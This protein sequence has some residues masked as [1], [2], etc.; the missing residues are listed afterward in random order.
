MVSIFLILMDILTW[1]LK[2]AGRDHL[3]GRRLSLLQV[4]RLPRRTMFRIHLYGMSVALLV[5]IL[6]VIIPISQNIALD[7]RCI[8]ECSGHLLQPDCL[9]VRCADKCAL[10]PGQVEE[11]L[12][13]D[14]Q[15]QL[16]GAANLPPLYIS[17]IILLIFIAG[18]VWGTPFFLM[19]L[20]FL[21]VTQIVSI[22][23]DF[24]PTYLP[25]F[26]T[27]AKWYLWGYL[28]GILFAILYND[29]VYLY[30]RIFLRKK[31]M[32]VFAYDTKKIVNII[33]SPIKSE[34]RGL[35]EIFKPLSWYG[36]LR[37]VGST[38]LERDIKKINEK[39]TAFFKEENT[40]VSDAQRESVL[41]AL[42]MPEARRKQ[43]QADILCDRME[44]IRDNLQSDL[45]TLFELRLRRCLLSMNYTDVHKF[46][47]FA[48]NQ[49]TEEQQ[50]ALKGKLE[51]PGDVAWRRIVQAMER[52]FRQFAT[53]LQKVE[54]ISPLSV[55]RLLDV[56]AGLYDEDIL[57]IEDILTEIEDHFEGLD[58]DT[59]LNVQQKLGI[60]DVASF[61]D[62]LKVSDSDPE[63]E[64]DF[65][66]YQSI[67]E[68]IAFLPA[69]SEAGDHDKDNLIKN[70]RRYFGVLN[71]KC[72]LQ[73]LRDPAL[74]GE[75]T[76]ELEHRISELI[77][78][79]DER[80][81]ELLK[82]IS[83]F[84]GQ[85][86]DFQDE[87]LLRFEIRYLYEILT[88]N[89]RTSFLG[90]WVSRFETPGKRHLETI[91]DHLFGELTR[92]MRLNQGDNNKIAR[93][94]LEKI[95]TAGASYF[96]FNERNLYNYR[97]EN[98]PVRPYT[99]A[100]V[101][102]PFLLS[103]DG[104]ENEAGDY[105]LDLIRYRLDLFLQAVNEALYNF[106]INEV[107]G[108][109]DIWSRIRIVTV[110]DPNWDAYSERADEFGMLQPSLNLVGFGDGIGD[111][112][113]LD[114]MARMQDSYSH[115]L[116]MHAKDLDEIPGMN[117]QRL[118]EDTDVIIALSAN[119]KYTR[120]S[121]H[122]S[123][124]QEFQD[125][126]NF[127]D[128]YF[129]NEPD[130]VP[131]NFDSDPLAPTEPIPAP[132]DF[133]RGSKGDT[134]HHNRYPQA[135]F[136]FIHE[137]H[138]ARKGRIAINIWGVDN[139]TYIHEFAHAMSSAFNGACVD[140]YYPS[141]VNPDRKSSFYVN[142][143][144]QAIPSIGKMSPVH[145]AFAE[146]NGSIFNSDLSH[147][148]AEENWGAY[149]PD[150]DPRHDRCTMDNA[151]GTYCFDGL[152][153]NFIYDR[154]LSKLNRPE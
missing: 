16:A 42:S 57:S 96:K 122:Y 10:K 11:E 38:G 25:E 75:L 76:T 83:L 98:P 68:Q 34:T 121:A 97:I 3:F 136:R 70:A 69:N 105:L 95:D 142:R 135:P 5:V 152:I 117:W 113:S 100:F 12:C 116:E 118:Y 87:N 102:N 99:I 56:I 44:Y 1:I 63:R 141:F 79:Q 71:E 64:T 144:E 150:R 126:N 148:S 92:L 62:Q 47:A 106:E 130:G 24:S 37:Q 78:Q 55:P 23:A 125:P 60:D 128:P 30:I 153:A 137:Y 112:E 109:D 18:S 52:R 104:D 20:L 33:K 26:I 85:E 32:T 77:N 46:F 94:I 41:R 6:V 74:Q 4:R 114:A 65:E 17:L 107:L 15:M 29:V 31:V 48:Y 58:D 7:S 91:F 133:R 19:V 134:I 9:E 146:Y 86:L 145:K 147:P 54:L 61:I 21:F 115:I 151:A 45:K 101:A 28:I 14:A 120:A 82:R 35:L 66:I 132:G 131:Y 59:K 36:R 84:L 81:V 49:L 108:Q 143:L 90:F 53:L 103:R 138:S 73:F 51:V 111:G 129:Q 8:G 40:D 139:D 119:L 140:E 110:F 2:Q 50:N 93:Q 80:A 22:W 39:L 13:L 67:I 123:D 27:V 149:F 89:N 154:L 88:A 43:R 127:Q 124:W 72:R